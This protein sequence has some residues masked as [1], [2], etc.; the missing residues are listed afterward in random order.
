VATPPNTTGINNDL[1]LNTNTGDLLQKTG[2]A[3]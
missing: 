2:G 1:F 3:W